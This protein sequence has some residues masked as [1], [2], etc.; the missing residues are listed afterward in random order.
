MKVPPNTPSN[1]KGKKKLTA[2]AL[3]KL[4]AEIIASIKCEDGP[5][6]RLCTSNLIDKSASD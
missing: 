6:K 1:V 3:A 5:K 2:K 4:E